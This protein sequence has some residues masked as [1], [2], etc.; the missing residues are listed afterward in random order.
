MLAVVNIRK[1]RIH[2][3]PI[4][5]EQTSRKAIYP[6]PPLSFLFLGCT[7]LRRPKSRGKRI[8]LSRLSS[9]L[10]GEKRDLQ[11]SFYAR[12]IPVPPVPSSGDM[13]SQKLE[14]EA[15]VA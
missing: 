8:S 11:G 4:G 14:A 9:F 10:K 15:L 6:C 12:A 13:I 3:R 7:Y 2:A 1:H 5:T